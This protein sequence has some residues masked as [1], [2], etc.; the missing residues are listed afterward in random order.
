MEDD[1]SLPN[2]EE[3]SASENKQSMKNRTDFVIGT[4]LGTSPFLILISSIA[5]GLLG[6]ILS[7][8]LSTVSVGTIFFLLLGTIVSFVSG[9]KSL[10]KGLFTGFFCAIMLIVAFFALIQV[11]VILPT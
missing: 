4:G 6:G 10:A 9:R 5:F 3:D 2:I 8:T 7:D 11:G 1:T